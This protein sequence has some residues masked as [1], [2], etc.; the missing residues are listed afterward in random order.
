MRRG[1][2]GRL[3]EYEDDEE[4]EEEEEG[5]WTSVIGQQRDSVVS[6]NEMESLRLVG[7]EA[8]SL[9]DT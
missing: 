2:E 9:T 7:A 4:E 3:L 5:E 8:F 1:C 6:N